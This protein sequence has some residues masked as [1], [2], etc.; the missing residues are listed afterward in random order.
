MSE[1]FPIAVVL[2]GVAG[3]AAMLFSKLLEVRLPRDGAVFQA[4]YARRRR[5]IGRRRFWLRA[6]Y[7]LPW[8][9]AP[10]LAGGDAK[11]RAL[12]AAARVSGMIFLAGAVAV[13][14]GLAHIALRMGSH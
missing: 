14:A 6:R 5:H 8:I 1:P 7:Y 11:V 4:L 9:A 12:L 13:L 10:D 3:F 2:T